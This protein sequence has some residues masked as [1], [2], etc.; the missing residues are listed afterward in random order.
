M[1]LAIPLLLLLATIAAAYVHHQR[2][3]PKAQV[4]E[5]EPYQEPT[6][7]L[8]AALEDL[9]IRREK[10]R[11]K[12]LLRGD[13]V[14]LRDVSV[15]C[16]KGHQHKFQRFNRGFTSGPSHSLLASRNIANFDHDGN[17]NGPTSFGKQTGEGLGWVSASFGCPTCSA[18]RFSFAKFE[19]NAYTTCGNHLVRKNLDHCPMC[20]EMERSSRE[21]MLLL[22]KLH[23]SQFPQ[24]KAS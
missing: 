11:R 8:E 6:A 10:V 4:M 13:V 9:R 23:R 14:E 16:E 17:F 5:L 7:Q 3:K 19:H 24:M 18:Q 15:I 20:R 1:S 22:A 21:E 2:S 12:L